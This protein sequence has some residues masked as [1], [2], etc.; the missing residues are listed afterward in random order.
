MSLRHRQ[1]DPKIDALGK[2]DI[3]SH[4]TPSELELLASASTALTLEAG[5]VLCRQGSLGHEF[6]VISEGEVSVEVDGRQVAVLG[7]GSFFGEHSLLAHSP[8]NATVSAFTEISVFVFGVGEFS[9][10]LH[11]APHAAAD[12]LIEA[13]RR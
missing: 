6:F 7:P 8:R 11:D 9:T 2:I 12:M 5:T 1:H 4:C 10:M 3:F 13:S